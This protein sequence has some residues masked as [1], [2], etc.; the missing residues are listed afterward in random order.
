MKTPLRELADQLVMVARGFGRDHFQE[1]L[2]LREYQYE[3]GKSIDDIWQLTENCLH[4][5]LT[6]QGKEHSY[7][8]Q[9]LSSIIEPSN[10]WK[11]YFTDWK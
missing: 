5:G 4:Q 6:Q 9:H 11:R 10:K 2:M 3:P 1:D 8:I 7:L